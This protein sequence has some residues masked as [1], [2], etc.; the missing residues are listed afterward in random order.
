M[1]AAAVFDQRNDV[2]AGF[3][4]VNDVGGAGAAT[5]QRRTGAVAP[6]D[7]DLNELKGWTVPAAIAF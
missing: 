2:V 7:V 4:F 6:F 5:L 1:V 3:F